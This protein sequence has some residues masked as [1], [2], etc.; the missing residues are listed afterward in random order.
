MSRINNNEYDIRL[1]VTQDD[2]FGVLATSFNKMAKSLEERDTLGQYV[3]ESVLKLAKNS[4]QFEEAKLGK[5]ANYT[6]L[7]SDLTGFKRIQNDGTANEIEEVIMHSLG[8]F[9]SNAKIFEGEIDKVM[10]EKIL[11]TFSH[12]K[13]GEKQAA[14]SAIELAKAVLSEFDSIEGLKPVF[15]INSGKVIS[16]IVGTPSVRMDYTVIGD[17]VNI[18]ARLCSLAQKKSRTIIISDS[19]M[20]LLPDKY[21]LDKLGSNK[22]KGKQQEVD[23]Y[24]FSNPSNTQD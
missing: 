20:K 11:I 17:T 5:E 1:E 7:F 16:G 23:A 21:N 2:E 10:A 19:T 24:S 6:V 18:A 8:V 12:E 14:K 13:L 4:K 15:G 3:S 9:F 22:I